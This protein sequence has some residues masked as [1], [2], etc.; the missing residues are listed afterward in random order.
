MFE[1]SEKIWGGFRVG[2]H[3]GSDVSCSHFV[4]VDGH[5]DKWGQVLVLAD[6]AGLQNKE[7]EAGWA[8]TRESE[9]YA[10]E[11]RGIIAVSSVQTKQKISESK[12]SVVCGEKKVN[13]LGQAFMFQTKEVKTEG[14]Q[15][16]C[17]TELTIMK[18]SKKKIR[19]KV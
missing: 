9:K 2:S 5:V 16:W 7:C 11:R 18:V 3:G 10:L 8:Q 15:G 19:P 6:P 1:D 17:M 4:E 13:S 12:A 14:R